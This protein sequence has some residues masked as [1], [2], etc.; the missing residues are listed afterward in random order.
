MVGIGAEIAER[1][2]IFPLSRARDSQSLSRARV[3][4]ILDAYLLNHPNQMRH[5]G[6]EKILKFGT[7]KTPKKTFLDTPVTYTY[8]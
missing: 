6:S 7:L 1:G 8:T 4:S 5:G 2:R 3:K